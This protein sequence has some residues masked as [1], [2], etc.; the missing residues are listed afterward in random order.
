MNRKREGRINDSVSLKEALHVYKNLL[1]VLHLHAGKRVTRQ[2]NAGFV[3]VGRKR[4]SA[5][6]K[7]R[8]C[9]GL[10]NWAT[11]TITTRDGTVSRPEVKR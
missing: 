1:H 8:V 5:E 2:V 4:F 11:K 3:F 7:M 9:G 10:G 6:D